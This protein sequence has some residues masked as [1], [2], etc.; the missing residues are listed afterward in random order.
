MFIILN[1]Q[2]KNI[3]FKQKDFEMLFNKSDLNLKNEF[4][5]T[6]FTLLFLNQKQQNIPYSINQLKNWWNKSNYENQKLTIEQLLLNDNGFQENLND[7]FEII[8]QELNFKP[9]ENFFKRMK[10][11]KYP[12][13][14]WIE[15]HNQFFNLE[16]ELNQKQQNKK[17]NKI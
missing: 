15:K 12:I 3:N 14:N 17:R 9:D 7:I 10:K 6:I 8:I 2:E 1:N 13:V 5:T 4:N 11:Q 16:K